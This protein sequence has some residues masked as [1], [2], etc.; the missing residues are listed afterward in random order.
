ML[1]ELRV[2][3]V[4]VGFDIERITLPL[5]K[6]R[7]DKV[8]LLTQEPDGGDAKLYVEEIVKKLKEVN[9]S[10]INEI[11]INIRDI[12]KTLNEIR[13]IIDVEKQNNIFIN[14]STGSKICS[15]AGVMAAMMCKENGNFIKPYY[16]IPESYDYGGNPIKKLKPQTIGMKDVLFIPTYKTH[17]PDKKLIDVLKFISE[18]EEVTKQQIVKFIYPETA[19]K[20]IDR[21]HLSKMYMKVTRAYIHKLIDEW[22]LIEVDGIGKSSIIRLKQNGKDMIKFLKD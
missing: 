7:A 21:T 19:T 18:K 4:P 22:E 6:M 3:I 9:I 13:K 8:Y 17:L 5:I 11:H 2:H 14:V 10:D 12:Y 1:E 15:I 20:K 16:V